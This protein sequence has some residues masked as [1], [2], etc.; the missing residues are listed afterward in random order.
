MRRRGGYARFWVEPE[1]VEEF[2]R[3]SDARRAAWAWRRYVTAARAAAPPN[4]LEVRYEE[5]ATNPRAAAE[6]LATHLGAD[7]ELLAQ[8][9]STMHAESVGRWRRDLNEEQLADIEAEAGTLLRELHDA[10][11]GLPPS[12][13]R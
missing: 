10:R 7:R 13:S 5:L 6:P 8:A 11:C 2:D 1:R 12:W 4:V 9:L 3:A